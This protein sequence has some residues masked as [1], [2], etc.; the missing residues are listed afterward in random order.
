MAHPKKTFNQP[1]ESKTVEWLLDKDKGLI[2]FDAK[3][4]TTEGWWH[5]IKTKPEDDPLKSK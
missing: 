2:Y 4:Q 1:G 5:R 3:N